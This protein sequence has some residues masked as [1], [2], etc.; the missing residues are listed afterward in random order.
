MKIG[1]V[2]GGSGGHFYPII[3]V[4]EKIHER[5]RSEKLLEPQLYYFA[6]KSYDKKALFDNHIEFV[7]ISAGKIRKYSSIKNFLDLFKTGWGVVKALWRVL[8]IF[9]DVIFST[10]SYASFPVLLAARVFGIPV[11]IHESDVV[12]GRANEWASSFA[13]KIGTS[14]PETAPAFE[15][16]VE[17]MKEKPDIAVVG[18]PIR[19]ELHIVADHGAREYLNLEGATPVLLIIGG[20]QGAQALNETLLD[21]FPDLLKSYQVIHQTGPDKFKEVEQ[22]ASVYLE[23]SEYKERYKPF[24]FLNTLALRMA[25]GAADIIISRAGAG[26]IFEIATWGKPSII[27]PLDED[28]SHNQRDN[29]FAYGRTGAADVIENKNLTPNLLI[30]EIN[31]LMNDESKRK[32]MGKAA[33]AFSRTDAAE[34]IAREII[35]LALEHER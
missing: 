5:I 14:F 24:A 31:R 9:P 6:P 19:R 21:T 11:I 22:L 30:S 35:D 28:V 34:K 16:K 15:K 4:V 2:G 18:H 13:K 25:A 32:E 3:A 26:G 8:T 23:K 10:G 20:S 27:V 33:K 12:P 29:A 1:F 7:P 17:K